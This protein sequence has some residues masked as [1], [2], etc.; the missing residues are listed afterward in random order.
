MLD[1][2]S[3][4]ATGEV[5]EPYA[6]VLPLTVLRHE[7]RRGYAASVEDA[8]AARGGADRSA[9]ARCR[10]PDPR[11]LHPQSADDPRSGAPGGQRSRH[12]GGR[13]ERSRVS[14]LEATAA[15]SVRAHL[16][17]S[18]VTVPG[19][20]DLVSGYGIIRLVALQERHAESP[21]AELLVTGRLGRQRGA[22]LAGRP[23]CAADRGSASWSGTISASRP[24]PCTTDYRGSELWAARARLRAA[25]IPPA[26]VEPS[27]A[28][29]I[30]APGGGGLMM[31]SP[32]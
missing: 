21:A 6:R 20:N 32:S 9:Q 1:D 29:E 24:T 13:G 17:A 15:P 28:G 14:R 5:L 25:P 31:T 16:F 27:W 3:N 4:D 8:A 22:L 23:L 12:R 26:P 19:V 7:N 30:R 18:V 10:D 11:G 2:G